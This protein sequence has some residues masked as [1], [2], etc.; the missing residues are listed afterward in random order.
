MSSP[1]P[2]VLD[3]DP[4]G[5]TGQPM[6]QRLR[7]GQDLD[8]PLND[9]VEALEEKWDVLMEFLEAQGFELPE[10]LTEL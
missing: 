1:K 3:N 4:A 7:P 5:A 8:I 10:Q 2:L 6:L 9:R